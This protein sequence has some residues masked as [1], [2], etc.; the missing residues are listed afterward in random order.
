MYCWKPV[1]TALG[2]VREVNY[3]EERRPEYQEAEAINRVLASQVKGGKTLLFLRHMYSLHVPFLNGDPA[4][5]WMINPDHLRTPQDWEIF[6]QKEGITF[7]A[8]SPYYPEAIEAPLA[9]M[10]AKGDLV[11]VARSV[12]QDFQ[13]M[14]IAG[15]RAEIPGKAP[16][17]TK[18]RMITELTQIQQICLLGELPIGGG[19]NNF[20]RIDKVRPTPSFQ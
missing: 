15:E 10:E 11:P 14:R 7:V 3:L 19:A 20:S 16:L 9:E 4:T 2:I 5:S 18:P 6:F 12:V 1:V 17:K 8:R 13:G